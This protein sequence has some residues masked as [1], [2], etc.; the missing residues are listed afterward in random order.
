[1]KHM[2]LQFLSQEDVVNTGLT[3]K[4]TIAIVEEVFK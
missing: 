1:M 2:D 4:E 3:M